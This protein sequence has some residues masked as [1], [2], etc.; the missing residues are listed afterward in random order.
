MKLLTDTSDLCW[1]CTGAGCK[2]CHGTGHL[3]DIEMKAW[4]AYVESIKRKPIDEPK[5]EK[6]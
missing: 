4:L 5:T 3:D 2:V 6:K 1:E